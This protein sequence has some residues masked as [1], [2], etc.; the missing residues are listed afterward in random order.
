MQG[1]KRAVLRVTALRDMVR[2]DTVRPA[3]AP[4]A[5]V[6]RDDNPSRQDIP[7][8]SRDEVM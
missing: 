6:R 2:L 3:M 5:M 7:N 8:G 4:R 1:L